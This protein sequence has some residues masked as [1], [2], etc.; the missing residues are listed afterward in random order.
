MFENKIC[1]YKLNRLKQRWINLSRLEQLTEKII[2]H[3][4]I[5][6]L[7]TKFLL[8]VNFATDEQIIPQSWNFKMKNKLFISNKNR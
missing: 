3:S 8:I 2:R 5:L 1:I 4:Y 7:L 6:R